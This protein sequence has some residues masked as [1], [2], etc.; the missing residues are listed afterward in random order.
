[1]FSNVEDY[2]FIF[3][4]VINFFVYKFNKRNKQVILSTHFL[5][6]FLLLR[7]LFIIK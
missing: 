3:K 4:F 2:L 6:L 1:M 5:N 7:L